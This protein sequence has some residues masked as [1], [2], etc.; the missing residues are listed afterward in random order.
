MTSR[1]TAS[2][3]PDSA[4]IE[5]QQSPFRLGLIGRGIDKSLAPAFHTIAGQMLGLDVTYELLPRDPAFSTQLDR[6]LE[7]LGAAGYRGV[8]I[9]VPFKASAWQAA[10]DAADEVV[11]TGVAN[12]LLLGPAGPTNA[13]N[14]DFSGFKWAYG[15][16]FADASPGTV[17]LLG[18]GGVG[19]ATAAALVDLGATAIRIYDI[20]ADRSHALADILR[21]RNAALPVDVAVSAE[22]A[23]DGVDGV[24]NGT[25][26]GM[27]FQPGTPVDLAAI[28]DQ[29]WLFDAIYS[30]IETELMAR[31]AEAKLAR[32]TGF[33]LFLGQAI[34]AFEI[35]TG[36]HLAPAVLA[37]LEARMWVVQH[38]R[39]FP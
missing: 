32:I 36:H 7:E 31:A 1:P 6:L 20:F 26:V 4:A 13:F 12:T 23:V 15:R 18:A 19:T 8:N 38:Q 11:S 33:D 14:T 35:F 30:P 2:H 28:G 9:T 34:D 16:R 21:H 29:R 5:S 10:S 24:V 37:E 22:E 3:R 39:E 25:P 17:A 27:Y